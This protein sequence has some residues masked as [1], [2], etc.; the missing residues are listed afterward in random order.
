[1]SPLPILLHCCVCTGPGWTAKKEAYFSVLAVGYTGIT[2]LE[3]SRRTP[4]PLAFSPFFVYSSSLKSLEQ[5]ALKICEHF[6]QRTQR[7]VVNT[8]V[9]RSKNAYEHFCQA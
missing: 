5:P 4:A 9:K 3:K 7:I 2:S 6:C 8:F 1:M